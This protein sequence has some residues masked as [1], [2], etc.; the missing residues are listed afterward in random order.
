ME[1]LAVL[2]P[3]HLRDGGD[4]VGVGLTPAEDAVC[5]RKSGFVAPSLALAVGKIHVMPTESFNEGADIVDVGGGVGN[6]DD[7]VVKVGGNAFEVLDGFINYLSK[8]IGCGAATLEHDEPF[9]EAGGGAER[10]EG[11]SILVD[12]GLVERRHQVEQGESSTGS[13]RVL[14]SCPSEPMGLSFL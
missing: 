3:Q 13:R 12:G 5:P 9:E 4:L 2:W 8:P 1:F 6:E 14:E 7:K 11:D 10:G